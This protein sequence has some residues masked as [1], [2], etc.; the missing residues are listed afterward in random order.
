MTVIN[1]SRPLPVYF[2]HH[3][4]ASGYISQVV[5]G[6]C[7]RANLDV[8]RVTS[9]DA[10]STARVRRF[11]F[12]FLIQQ[13]ADQRTM[14]VMLA[15]RSFRGFHVIRD[16]RDVLV[17]AYFSHLHSHRLDPWL[18]AHRPALARLGQEDGMLLE[19]ETITGKVLQNM[20]AWAYDDPRIYE[21]RFEVLTLRP[22]P[23]FRK[24]FRF[25]GVP[26]GKD[27]LH[28]VVSRKSFQSLSQG[29]A[30]G[31]ENIYHHYRK[32]IVGD[33]KNYFTERIKHAFK[34]HYGQL[35]I[36]LGYEA[37]HDW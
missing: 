27:D 32:G 34:Q 25:L 17:S 1:E 31:Q 21:T 30:K 28:Q 11:D 16:P 36:D 12:D 2:G 37:N 35:L 8:C 3:K 23:E 19:L 22:D 18:R 24:I 10:E 20:Q 9:S 33:W 14:D 4:C 7:K 5:S 26:C 13:N 29:R 15:G 6:L